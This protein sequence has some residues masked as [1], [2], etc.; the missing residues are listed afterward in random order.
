MNVLHSPAPRQSIGKNFGVLKRPAEVTP[1]PSTT[2][3][4]SK[5]VTPMRI[6]KMA[7]VPVSASDTGGRRVKRQPKPRSNFYQDVYDMLEQSTLANSEL[8]RWT[9]DGMAF[10]YDNKKSDKLS[11]LL[12]EFGTYRVI[13]LGMVLLP[14]LLVTS[15][16]IFLSLSLIRATQVG[17]VPSPS[18]CLW[19]SQKQTPQVS[20]LV[21]LEV[22]SDS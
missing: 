2:A 15:I 10:T 14:F 12:T 21:L 5:Y 18:Q 9:D 3:K 6:A 8:I 11:Q 20:F 16:L 7:T 22:L 17:I 19:L 13:G 1:V 4:R